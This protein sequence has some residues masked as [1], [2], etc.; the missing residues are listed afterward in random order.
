MKHLVTRKENSAVEV[1]LTLTKEEV[2]PI[3]ASILKTLGT[4][5]EV[6]GFRKG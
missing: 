6:P 2:A 3:K 4:K 1:K 5:V